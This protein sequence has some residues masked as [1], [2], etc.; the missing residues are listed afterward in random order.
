MSVPFYRSSKGRLLFGLCGRIPRTDFWVGLADLTVMTTLAVLLLGHRVRGGSLGQFFGVVAAVAM[1][2][3][4]CLVGFRKTSAR[5]RQ[6]GLACAE[7]LAA[8][9]RSSPSTGNT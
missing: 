4:Y 9:R 7:L 8:I 6:I 5:S 3:P 1:V 2:S